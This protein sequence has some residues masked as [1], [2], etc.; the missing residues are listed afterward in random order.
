MQGA[1]A[2]FW[3]DYSAHTFDTFIAED[4]WFMIDGSRLKPPRSDR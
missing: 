3:V 1:D 2:P 4:I